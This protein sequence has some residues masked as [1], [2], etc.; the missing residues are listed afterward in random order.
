MGMSA[1]QP[2]MLSISFDCA[3][4]VLRSAAASIPLALLYESQYES[5]YGPQP[6]IDY[7]PHSAATVPNIV[8]NRF[9]LPNCISYLSII[10][11]CHKDGQVWWGVTW[12]GNPKVKGKARKLVARSPDLNG[13]CLVYIDCDNAWSVGMSNLAHPSA[14]LAMN[15]NDE[16]E[17]ASK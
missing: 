15:V 6:F 7:T 14:D 3:S 9:P 13:N 1:D 16:F 10:H 12:D 17:R 5:Q 11:L 4:T 2:R 8:R